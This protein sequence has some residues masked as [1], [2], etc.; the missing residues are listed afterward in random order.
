MSLRRFYASVY[1][2][3]MHA[4]MVI[5][6]SKSKDQPCKVAN[7]THGQLNRENSYEVFLCPHSRPRI[8]S[9]ETGS[10]VYPALMPHFNP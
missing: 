9:R 7:H 2:R 3:V 6:D 5:T 8:R 10:A 1:V 4:C